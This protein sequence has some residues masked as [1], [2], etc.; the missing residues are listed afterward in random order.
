[1][2]QKINLVLL[3]L[4]M[5]S[6]Q[7]KKTDL[8][9][10]LRDEIRGYPDSIQ[11][12]GLVINYGFKHQ[13]LAHQ[14][15]NYD[16]VMIREFFYKPNRYLFDSCFN[17]FPSKKYSLLEI[18]KWNKT[19]LSNYDTIVWKQ[20]EFLIEKNI[21]SLLRSHIRAV[22]SITGIQGK[23]K[24]LV[25]YP[26][27][28]FGISGGCTSFSMAFDMMYKCLDENY[29]NRTIP[30]EIEHIIYENVMGTHPEFLTGIGVTLDEGLATYFEHK[31]LQI[32]TNEILIGYKWFLKNE[33]EI[34][35]KL[36]PFLFLSLDNNPL[37]Y[38]FNRNNEIT[39]LIQNAPNR[40]IEQSL[41]YT[42]GVRIIE[43]YE[44]NY[45]NGSWK[46]IYKISPKRFYEKS[47]YAEYV[48]GM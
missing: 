7:Q 25:Y 15:G 14:N 38:H 39:P 24:F 28:G 18:I 4:T 41:G 32:P 47:G 45:G 26:P 30:H 33:K 1:M 36:E 42:L 16:S 8:E 37:L 40:E 6:C 12:G 34:F 13:I 20:T 2:K 43:Q 48:N 44:K 27:K 23:G 3:V 10:R 9:T 19:Y 17:F 31:Y 22:Q 21:D 11:V 35:E 46:D 5:I 29:L